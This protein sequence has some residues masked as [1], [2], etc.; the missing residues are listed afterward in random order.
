MGLIIKC[1]NGFGCSW[2]GKFEELLSYRNECDMEMVVCIN[3]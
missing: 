3:V 2:K 1:L